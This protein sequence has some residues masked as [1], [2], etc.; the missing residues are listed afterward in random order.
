MQV[1]DMG[2]PDDHTAPS[3][4]S[5]G[6]FRCEVDASDLEAFVACLALGT[7][8]AMRLGTWPLDAGTWTLARPE[9][10][11]ALE[12]SGLPKEL[13]DVLQRA[14]ELSALE[15]LCGRPAVE[16]ELDRML[17]V[18]RARLAEKTS[19]LW[20]ATWFGLDASCERVVTVE[21]N[22]RKL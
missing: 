19:S 5:K 12:V 20:R 6:T 7:L 21:G 1:M 10:W 2:Y 17:E 14:D 8:E 9:F 13:L 4:A 18:V 16:A 22:S 15:A 11:Q 3:N